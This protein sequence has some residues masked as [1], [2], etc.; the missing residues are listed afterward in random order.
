MVIFINLEHLPFETKMKVLRE[1]EIE[2][3][4]N[5]NN[6]TDYYRIIYH[7]NSTENDDKRNSEKRNDMI[8]GIEIEEQIDMINEIKLKLKEILVR[9]AIADFVV[10]K[11]SNSYE[12]LTFLERSNAE[13]KGILH[14]RHCGMEFEDEMQLGN[15][16]RIHFII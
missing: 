14:C 1:I 11:D 10:T 13:S 15:H 7:D 12:S 6:R 3:F 2:F 5:D 4:P 8:K 16:L 9:L